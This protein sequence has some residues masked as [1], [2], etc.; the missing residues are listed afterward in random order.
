MKKYLGIFISSSVLGFLALPIKTGSPCVTTLDFCYKWIWFGGVKYIAYQIR[1]FQANTS[2]YP[3][4][5]LP[6]VRLENLIVFG[7]LFGFAITLVV[8]TY[9]ILKLKYP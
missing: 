9:R 8:K 1:K 4:V 7:V 6:P 3:W 5:I 2:E